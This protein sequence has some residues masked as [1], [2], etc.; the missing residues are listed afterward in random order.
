[1]RKHAFRN[2]LVPVVTVMGMQIAL[3]LGGAVL[4]ETTFEWKGLGYELAEYLIRRDFLAVQGIVTVI[5]FV[6]CDR[7]L[8][9]R[10][11]RRVRRPPSEV[12]MRVPGLIVVAQSHGLQRFMLLLG[13][14]LVWR[15]FLVLA[16]FAPWLAPYDF[17]ARPRRR[18]R[19]SAPSSRRRADHWFGTT[20]GGTDVLSRVIYGAR[21]A[22]EVIV[23][24]VVCLEPDRRAA[25]PGLGLPR[26]LARP[27]RS[28][29]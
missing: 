20:V 16:V 5:A 11:H 12:L 27:R 28:S 14:G 3:L 17:N 9:D 18:R 10:R 6:V 21:T 24:A 13:F 19:C 7:E 4:T 23:L 8:P 2:A 29:S 22:V 15:L 1:M 25:R 26:R